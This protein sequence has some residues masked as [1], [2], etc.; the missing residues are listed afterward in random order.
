[1][2]RKI[3]LAICFI[4][5]LVFIGSSVGVAVT[6]NRYRQVDKTYGDL[7]NRYVSTNSYET[8]QMPDGEVLPSAPI[9]VDFPSLLQENGDIIGWLYCEDTPINYPVVQSDDNDDYLRRDLHGNYLVSGT[10]FVDYRCGAVGTGQNYIIYGHFMKNATMFGTLEKYKEQSYFDEHPVLYY[11]TS[12]KDYMIELFAGF[13][14]NA[15]ADIYYPNFGDADS[16]EAVLQGLKAQS[17]F[18][19]GISVTG[20]DHIV[21]LSTCSH[22]FDNAR[23]VV[24]GK[25]TCLSDPD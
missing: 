3:Y 6:L 4:L 1:M 17:T 19:S 22:D 14:T 8:E 18:N 21:T 20:E 5:G 2:K 13:V 16:F 7:Q 12:D 11:L 15:N 10:L 9:A 24:F 25:L 23:Y